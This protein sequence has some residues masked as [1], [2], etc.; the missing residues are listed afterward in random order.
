MAFLMMHHHAAQVRLAHAEILS[1]EFFM[2]ATSPVYLG[3]SRLG[4]GTGLLPYTELTKDH[5]KDVFDVHQTGD[6]AYRLGGIA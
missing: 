1:S 2:Y 3:Q 5:I 4:F 6:L